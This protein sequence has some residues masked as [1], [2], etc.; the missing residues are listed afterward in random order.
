MLPYKG[1][2]G[3]AVAMDGVEHPDAKVMPTPIALE[4]RIDLHRIGVPVFPF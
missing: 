2:A 4:K 1:S 3:G